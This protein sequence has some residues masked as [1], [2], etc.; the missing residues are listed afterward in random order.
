M[1]RS[2]V[3]PLLLVFVVPLA[4]SAVLLSSRPVAAGPEKQASA[5]PATKKLAPVATGKPPAEK[6]TA[7]IGEKSGATKS[8]APP[9]PQPPAAAAAMVKQAP[10]PPDQSWLQDVPEKSGVRSR[11]KAAVFMIQGDDY[12]QPVRAAVVKTL[13]KRGLNVTANL[14]P[15]DSA[16]QYREM[17]QTLQLGVFIDGELR[18]DGAHQSARIRLRSGVSGRAIATATFTGPTKKIVGDVGQKLWPKMG[19]AILRS[20]STARQR[21]PERAPLRI[22]AGS[23]EDSAIS[24]RGV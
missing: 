8:A 14:R 2:P 12:Y 13:R 10:P 4:A 6:E 9:A 15:V 3:F 22:E 19:G 17:S 5:P 11:G 16:A 1:R 20:C 24:M 21:R 23:P 18:G 7:A